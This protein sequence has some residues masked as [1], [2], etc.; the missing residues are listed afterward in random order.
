MPNDATGFS[1][2]MLLTCIAEMDLCYFE[3]E[4]DN[5]LLIKNLGSGI[6]RSA[7]LGPGVQIEPR[8]PK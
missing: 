6:V 5:L 3:A 2:L 7:V 4:I 1:D 8:P